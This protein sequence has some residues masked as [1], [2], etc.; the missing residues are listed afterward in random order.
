MTEKKSGRFIGNVE[1]M[2]L[3]ETEGELGIAL[4]ADM[5]NRGLGTEAILTLKDYGLRQLGLK[6]IFLRT[7]PNNARAIHVYE[8]CGFTEYA[9]DDA[10]VYMEALR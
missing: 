7:N 4:T 1:L 2:G 6:R 5:Q 9:R 8:K 10:H 3:T